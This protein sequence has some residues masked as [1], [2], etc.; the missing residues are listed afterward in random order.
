M[1]IIR[2]KLLLT[3]AAFAAC[4]LSAAD[5]SN[6]THHQSGD[7]LQLQTGDLILADFVAPWCASCLMES[8]QLNNWVSEQ[9]IDGLTFLAINI[10][11]SNP[12][13]SKVFLKRSK[14]PEL[15]NDPDGTLYQQLSKDVGVPFVV[16]AEAIDNN[17]NVKIHHQWLGHVDHN[18]LATVLKSIK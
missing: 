16:L 4:S 8:P 13:R 18:E 11:Q 12:K 10:D 2:M 14:L 9:Y 15:W 7:P 3:I 6:V 1:Q 5:F 17:G